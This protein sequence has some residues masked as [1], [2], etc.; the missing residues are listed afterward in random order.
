MY[1]AKASV[2]SL[3]TLLDSFLAELPKIVASLLVIC[4]AVTSAN[5]LL[6]VLRNLALA[7]NS[8][9][10]ASNAATCVFVAAIFALVGSTNFNNGTA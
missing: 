7:S 4:A 6:S 10:A 3:I 8:V 9:P 2:F 5:D 1:S